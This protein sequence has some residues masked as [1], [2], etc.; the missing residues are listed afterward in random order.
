MP[1]NAGDFITN[2]SGQAPAAL[3]SNGNLT[4]PA[5]YLSHKLSRNN[6]AAPEAVRSSNAE[7]RLL[8]T[9]TTGTE[10]AASLYVLL[11]TCL[12]QSVNSGAQ[13]YGTIEGG[14]DYRGLART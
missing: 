2:L 8:T 6:T 3:S 4:K 7:K 14:M 10:H 5:R 9:I 11:S 1:V 12:H 13:I